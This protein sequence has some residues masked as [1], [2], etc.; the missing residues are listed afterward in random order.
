MNTRYFTRPSED[1][2]GLTEIV[3][4]CCGAKD[5]AGSHKLLFPHREGCEIAEREARFKRPKEAHV[6]A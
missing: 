1:R 6:G 2:P 5:Y 3:C 4:R